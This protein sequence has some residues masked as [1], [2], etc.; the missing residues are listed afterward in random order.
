MLDELRD[1]YELENIAFP[2]MQ[3][4]TRVSRAEVAAFLGSELQRR[5]RRA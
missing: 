1:R 5:V 4:L 2:V 3:A